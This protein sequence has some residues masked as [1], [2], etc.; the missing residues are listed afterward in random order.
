[1]PTQ[2][3][4]RVEQREHG[5]RARVVAVDVDELDPGED[6][7]PDGRGPAPEPRRVGDRLRA[8]G[9]RAHAP[10]DPRR[11]RGPVARHGLKA[12]KTSPKKTLR[13]GTPTQKQHVDRG[14]REVGGRR[15]RAGQA[16]AHDGDED[17]DADRA[18]QHL[19][20]QR[21]R[22][23]R[24][25]SRALLEPRL[26]PQDGERDERDDEHDGGA[27]GEQPARDRQVLRGRRGR[28]PA[29]RRAATAT[30]ARG[31]RGGDATGAAGAHDG[32]TSSSAIWAPDPCELDLEAALD[33][34]LEAERAVPP[35]GTSLRHVVAVHVDLVGR[36][37][38]DPEADPVAAARRSASARRR[39]AG[40]R[41]RGSSARAAPRAPPASSCRS[42]PRSPSVVA[43]SRSRS[44]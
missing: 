13:N 21:A 20:R 18:A 24:G 25:R 6:E 1:M 23:G 38:R 15:L 35:A 37:G 3:D 33:V 43:S 9:R 28:G 8:G 27:P 4:R 32:D 16:G 19:E 2:L 39:A 30:A 22:A 17:R 44:W 11:R 7:D 12:A 29:R 41:R 5:Q 34:R 14:R 31:E 42:R 26:G 36:V 40:R 10:G